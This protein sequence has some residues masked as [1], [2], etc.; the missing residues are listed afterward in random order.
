MKAVRASR[1]FAAA[2]LTTSLLQGCRARLGQHELSSIRSVTVTEWGAPWT[3]MAKA[4]L[5]ADG[6]LQ[7]HSGQSANAILQPR[8]KKALPAKTTARILSLLPS[9]SLVGPENRAKLADTRRVKIRIETSDRDVEL[10]IRGP[11][12]KGEARFLRALNSLLPDGQRF[13]EQ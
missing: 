1:L 2:V 12:T 10:L 3:P 4:S 7:W 11:V 6:L 8:G 5:S 9:V 13:V